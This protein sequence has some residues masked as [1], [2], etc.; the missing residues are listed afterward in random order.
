MLKKVIA[1]IDDLGLYTDNLYGKEL[2][3]ELNRGYIAGFGLNVFNDVTASF[4]SDA[5]AVC[6]SLEYS[7]SGDTVFRAGKVALM[8]FAHCPF[9]LVYG[10][11][12]DS[13]PNKSTLYYENEDARY[14]LIR[15]RS[16][17]CDFTM[18]E[19]KMTIYPRMFEGKNLFYRFI[20]LNDSE[21][22]D[23]MK[24]IVEDC[25]E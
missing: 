16:V 21:K 17:A 19:D 25:S 7:S 22:R 6:A 14:M 10:R 2:A 5:D 23:M 11:N 1:S 13:C 4:F 9:S 24:I 8:S 15:R 3:R 20:G 12:C 18:Y